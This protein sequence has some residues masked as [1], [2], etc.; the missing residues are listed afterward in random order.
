[1]K[2]EKAP[3]GT[4]SLL[5]INTAAVWT[6]FAR[7]QA[8]ERSKAVTKADAAKGDQS[9]AARGEPADENTEVKVEIGGDSTLEVRFRASDD[10]TSAGSAT[11]AGAVASEKETPRASDEGKDAKKAQAPARIAAK[12]LRK[13]LFVEVDYR[14]RKGVNR[15]SRLVV[16][17]PIGGPNTSDSEPGAEETPAK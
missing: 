8:P 5:T 16:I 2:V 9:T 10:E 17:K 15:A 14:E 3:K 6:E 7:D 1:M 4:G 13:G 12:D 11:P